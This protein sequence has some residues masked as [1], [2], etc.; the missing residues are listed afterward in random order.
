V[1][2]TYDPADHLTSALYGNALT[3]LSYDIAGRKLT[4]DDPNMGLWSYAYD[5]LGNL[6]RQADARGQRIC[7]YYDGLNRPR[8]TLLGQT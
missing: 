2:Y 4:L 6:T 7:L 3:S 5:A 1:S 8:H